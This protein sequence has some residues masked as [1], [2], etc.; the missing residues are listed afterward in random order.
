[1]TRGELA[2]VL[3]PAVADERVLAAIAAV[4]RAAF[5]PAG[6]RHRA[7]ENE[8]LP[9]GAGQ[10][11]S[12]PLVVALMCELLAP[13]PRDRVLDVGTGSG[14]AA[15]VL[16]EL[17][18]EVWTVEVRDLA[19]TRVPG[20]HYVAGDG[21]A[22]LPGQAPFDAV[23][24]GAAGSEDRLRALLDQLA[25]GGRLVAPVER[26]GGQVLARFVSTLTGVQRTDHG[27]VRFVP[28]VA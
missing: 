20:V 3:R 22:G 8:A 10:T 26:R 21:L 15:A 27:H 4:D 9:I 23:H 12:Q 16:A 1:M 18:G 19:A 7:W 25:T 11:I 5:V 14:Y 13:G 24:V 17:A 6:V 28:L 2:E